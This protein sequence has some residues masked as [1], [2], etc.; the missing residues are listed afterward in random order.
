M[1]K[2]NVK[3]TAHCEKTF[4]VHA[5]NAEQAA[6]KVS[7]I[8]FDTDLITFSEDDFVTG[9]VDITKASAKEERRMEE[10][11]EAD[12]EEEREPETDDPDDDC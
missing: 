9:E 4:A 7:T 5:E 12:E 10:T 6:E 8:L 2:Y 3:L 11:E 1:N